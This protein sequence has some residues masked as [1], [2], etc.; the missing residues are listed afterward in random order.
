MSKWFTVEVEV[1]T[2]RPPKAHAQA[3]VQVIADHHIDASWQAAAMVACHPHV[4][5]VL[6]AKVIA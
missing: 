5:M 2:A 4:V 1:A 3:W 6:S